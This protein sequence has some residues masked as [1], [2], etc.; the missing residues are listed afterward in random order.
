ME[1][2]NG[3]LQHDLESGPCSWLRKN[4]NTQRYA[5]TKNASIMGLIGSVVPTGL[6]LSHLPESHGEEGGGA[7]R[8]ASEVMR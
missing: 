6:H 7:V 1:L 2:M 5:D 3:Q 4:F 8:G